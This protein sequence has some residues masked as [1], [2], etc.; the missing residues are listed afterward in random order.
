MYN[1]SIEEGRN[2]QGKLNDQNEIQTIILKELSDKNHS[3]HTE[4]IKSDFV[5]EISVD[6]RK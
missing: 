2:D 1:F 5:L 4:S 3:S 6:Y